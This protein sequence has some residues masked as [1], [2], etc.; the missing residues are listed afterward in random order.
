MNR[1]HIALA[2]LLL[3]APAP[4]Q[5]R[6]LPVVRPVR[7][8]LTQAIPLVGSVEP[9]QVVEIVPRITGYLQTVAVDIGDVVVRGQL[10]AEVDAPELEAMRAKA[11]FHRIEARAQLSRAEAG[12]ADAKALA[13]DRTLA[14]KVREASLAGRRADLDVYHAEAQVVALEVARKRALFERGAVTQEVLEEV[15]GRLA[16]AKARG[17]A[18]EAAIESAL[19]EVE[20][21]KARQAA[22][23]AAV[24]TAEADVV[25]AGAA[26]DTAGAEYER[27][28]VLVAF[29]SLVCP[30]EQAIVTERRLHTGAHVMA[31][32]DAV[33]VLMEVSRVRVVLSVPER[34]AAQVRAGMPVR[35]V[36]DADGIDPIEGMLTRTSGAL[37]PRTRTLRAEVELLNPDGQLL[38]GMFCHGEVSVREVEDAL[39]L[40]GGAIRSDSAGNFVWVVEGGKVRRTPVTLGLDD[41]RV[42]EVLS[43]LEGD[44]QV[45]AGN[46]GGLREG[47][48]IRALEGGGQ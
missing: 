35:L 43:G 12:V 27:V 14:I 38:P 33:C 40:P 16:M 22:A 39:T 46:I 10:V 34:N 20:A 45:I 28:E 24:R 37:D 8:N 29:K 11:G 25:A 7:E 48:A 18:A 31:D 6:A 13:L 32:A 47:D 36:F 5:E 17:L 15:E 1:S 4:A 21:S 23:Y 2:A 26:A 19:A 41:G 3:A 9:L 30:F 42:A 44:E